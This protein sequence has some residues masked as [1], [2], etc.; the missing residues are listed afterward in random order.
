M[1]RRFA[2]ILMSQVEA[3]SIY[4][5]DGKKVTVTVNFS[6]AVMPIIKFRMFMAGRDSK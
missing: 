6:A 5:K 2:A 3:G 1:S 4:S